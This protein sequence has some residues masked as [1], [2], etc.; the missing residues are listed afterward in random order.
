E[1]VDARLNSLSRYEQRLLTVDPADLDPD[2]A[3]DY[4]VLRLQIGAA[5]L[6]L[7]E[8]RAWEQN[9]NFYRNVISQ[10]VYTLASLQ[11]DSPDRR[12][13]LATERLKQVPD[14]LSAARD[15]LA[16]PPKIFT[17]IAIDEFGGTH[18]FIK[19]GLAQ[20][21]ADVKDEAV[22]TRFNDA[23]KHALDAIEK[24]IDWM[25]RDL[26]PQSTGSF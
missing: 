18:A 14:V 23:Q 10:G 15:N 8:V 24:F 3:F 7:A 9:P 19:T 22:R 17:E 5:R 21:F 6:D 1:A 26:L 2:S 12:M 25:R 11:F 13:N 20:A 16:H 4:E